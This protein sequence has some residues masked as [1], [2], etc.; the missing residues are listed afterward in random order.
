MAFVLDCYLEIDKP[1][2]TKREQDAEPSAL[3]RATE[4]ELMRSSLLGCPIRGFICSD[5][6]ATDME[7]FYRFFGITIMLEGQPDKSLLAN[8]SYF[9]VPW[10]GRLHPCMYSI[11]DNEEWHDLEAVRWDG[12]NND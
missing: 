8:V 1:K 9:K 11:P 2:Y 4:N 10:G 6:E 7:S 3:L 12:V 5:D